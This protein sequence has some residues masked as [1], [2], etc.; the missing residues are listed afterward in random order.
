MISDHYRFIFVHAGR[1]GGSSFERLAG[2]GITSD[3]RTKHLDNTDFP[4]KHKDFQY[5]Q[6][7][8]PKEFLAYFKFTIVRNPFDRLVSAWI[9]RTKVVKDIKPQTLSE[10]IEARHD[11]TKFSEKFKLRDL[12]LQDSIRQFDY[13]GRYENLT[14]TIN[15]LSGKLGILVTEIPHSNNTHSGR[16]QDYYDPETI[17]LVRQKYRLDIELFGYEFDQPAK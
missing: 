16:Y 4:E 3:V 6:T 1:T 15:Y 12:S 8:Y 7:T 5:Y 9:W 11:S 13:I 10:F 17:A 14:N 2:I